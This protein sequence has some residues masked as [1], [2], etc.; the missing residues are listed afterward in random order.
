MPSGASSAP[1]ACS[2]PGSSVLLRIHSSGELPPFHAT[3]QTPIWLDGELPGV[4]GTGRGTGLGSV[5]PW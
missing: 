3:L 1:R 2:N 5:L 4:P